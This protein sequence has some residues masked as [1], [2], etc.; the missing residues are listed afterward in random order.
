MILFLYNIGWIFFFPIMSLI[1]LLRAALGKEDIMRLKERFGIA[2]AVRSTRGIIWIHAASVGESRISI[3]LTK[4]LRNIYPK[5]RILI[6]TGTVTS[7]AIVRGLGSAKVVHQFLPMDNP[8]SLWL[9][10]R[11]W[12]PDLG[13]I[14]ESELWPNLIKTGYK[15]CPLILA[16]ARMSSR[17]FEKWKNY[18][19][20]SSDML[21]CFQHVLCQSK[22]DVERYKFLGAS[23]IYAGNLKYSSAPLEVNKIHLTTLR[24]MIGKRPVFLA[25][26]THA[27]D[28]EI[29]L[30]AYMK[31]RAN[32]PDLL[33]IIAPRHVSR[34]DEIKSL[35]KT[36]DLNVSVRSRKDH[37]TPSTE[38]YLADT[39]S[40]LGLFFSIADISCICGSFK[41]GGHNPIEAAYFDTYIVFGPD[42]SNFSD[43]T[44]E[45]LENKAATQ[46][47]D[48]KELSEAINMVLSNKV[49]NPKQAKFKILQNHASVMNCYL[50]HIKQTLKP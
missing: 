14:M 22:V 42:M 10:F 11:Y 2:S 25:A 30:N 3:T 21:K 15:F 9:F 17:S 24:S 26:S 29:I 4:Q 32:H 37:I 31:S 45:F 40:E 50:D 19:M 34:A 35:I 47:Q 44:E 33:A 49:P 48:D 1:L 12:R 8:I 23:P 16:N 5:H 27:G 7:A 43:V 46:V 39:M 20:L 13:I 6:T 36:H 18:R 28:E 41:N 38:I